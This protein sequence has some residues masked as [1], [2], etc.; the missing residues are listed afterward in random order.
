MRSQHCGY[1]CP[2]VKAPGY[3]C[4]QC[5]L[6]SL[7]IGP[8]S[9]KKYYTNVGQHWNKITF[10]KKWPSRLRVNTLGLGDVV[11]CHRNW[12]T[13][14]LVMAWHLTGANPLP[15]PILIYRKTSNIR[16]TLEG[17]KIVDHSDVVGASPVGAAPTTSS[18]STWIPRFNRLG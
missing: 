10:W 5:W 4:P 1:W 18:F 7:C 17:N 6:N 11:W 3:Q 12:L 14:V 8:V 9:Y 15:E 13:L 16:C 2:G